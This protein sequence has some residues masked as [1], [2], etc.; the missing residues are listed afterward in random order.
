M[1]KLNIRKGRCAFGLCLG[2][3]VVQLS[4]LITALIPGGIFGPRVPPA[5]AQEPLKP[6]EL[7]VSILQAVERALAKNWTIIRESYSPEISATNVVTEEAAFDPILNFE[8]SL[9]TQRLPTATGLAGGGGAGSEPGVSALETRNGSASLAQRFITGGNYELTLNASRQQTNSNFVFLNPNYSSDITLTLIHPLL[10]NFGLEFNRSRIR[11]A[12]LDRAISKEVFRQQVIAVV[13]QVESSYWDLVLARRLVEVS[14][15]SLE[16]ARDLRRRNK[17][18]I[19]A[20]VL[21]PIEIF[22]A[23]AAVAAREAEL[24][25]AQAAVK[26]A[27]DVLKSLLSMEEDYRY[28]EVTILP[29]DEPAVT[30]T[31]VSL[32]ESL[33]SGL[34][35]RPEISQ[36]KTQTAS[37][38]ISVRAARNQL[39]PALDVTAFFGLNGRGREVKDNLDVLVSS[40]RYH[41]GLSVFLEIPLGNRVAKQTLRRSRLEAGQAR[42]S[43]KEIQQLVSLEVRTAVRRLNTSLKRITATRAA[44]VLAEKTL[45]AE[46]KKFRV[47]LSTNFNILQFQNDLAIAQS[48]ETRTLIDY[49]KALVELQRATGTLLEVNS[50]VL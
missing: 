22:Q 18:Q 37:R 5:Q 10:R 6:V 19:E 4:G 27:E 9:T 39:R 23:E 16:L 24:I 7:R 38:D 15:R 11:I 41:A 1:V 44:R 20:G 17:I 28:Q 8:G 40:K 2:V 26:D 3:M 31:E 14:R 30:V 35:K 46:E 21:A 34:E 29:E 49:T 33:K 47:G 45:D 13:S 36:A 25:S 48:E 42:A 43:L 32:E 50:I 12:Q